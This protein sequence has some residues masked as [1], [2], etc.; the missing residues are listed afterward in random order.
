MIIFVIIT[1]ISTSIMIRAARLEDYV[2]TYIYIHVYLC[3][4]IYIHIYVYICVYREREM[5]VCLLVYY[6]SEVEK[7]MRQDGTLPEMKYYYLEPTDYIY[8]YIYIYIF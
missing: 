5:C 6:H 2:Y 4:Y 8:I 3:I 7:L 1:M